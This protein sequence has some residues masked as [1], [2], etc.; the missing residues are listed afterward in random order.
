MPRSARKAL[1][2]ASSKVPYRGHDPASLLLTIFEQ[3]HEAWLVQHDST[4]DVPKSSFKGTAIQIILALRMSQPPRKVRPKRNW[5]GVAWIEVALF[6]A[7]PLLISLQTRDGKGYCTASTCFTQKLKRKAY[8]RITLFPTT[9][10][11]DH[12]GRINRSCAISSSRLSPWLL[13]YPQPCRA[14]PPSPWHGCKDVLQTSSPARPVG[15][16]A[17]AR[18]RGSESAAYK[19]L[20]GH[21]L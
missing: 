15:S 16:A 5:A 3:G 19:E 18:W 17:A 11:Q 9:C 10:Y 1:C 6:P 2:A 21:A 13:A 8:L 14:L 7:L 20:L 12:R 4:W